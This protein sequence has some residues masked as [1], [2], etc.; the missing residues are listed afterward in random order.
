M[1]N[2]VHILDNIPNEPAEEMSAIY[3]GALAYVQPSFYE[4]FGF[5]VLDALQCGTPVAC[6]QTSSLL[7]VG[8]EAVVFF[9]PYSVTSMRDGILRAMNTDKDERW[10]KT[11]QA[12]LSQFSWKK[13][14]EQ[15]VDF[16]KK[17]LNE[18]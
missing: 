12:H 10:S 3:T 7:E 6:S 14:A 4:G 18:K 17:V 1:Q 13:T 5:P 16:Y 15:M 9:D 8:G 2:R 11:V